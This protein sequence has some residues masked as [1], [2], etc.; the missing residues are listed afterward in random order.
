M[1]K[2][3]HVKE[4]MVKSVMGLKLMAGLC[5]ILMIKY[6]CIVNKVMREVR[7]KILSV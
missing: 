7:L 4:L 2:V 5:N 3:D 6:T 1:K